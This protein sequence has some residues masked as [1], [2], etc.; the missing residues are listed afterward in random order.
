MLKNHTASGESLANISVPAGTM[1]AIPG[2][3]RETIEKLVL[4]ERQAADALEKAQIAMQAQGGEVLTRPAIDA[5]R[6]RAWHLRAYKAAG[7]EQRKVDE[8]LKRTRRAAIKEFAASRGWKHEGGFSVAELH[9]HSLYLTWCETCGSLC[10]FAV[11]RSQN[12]HNTGHHEAFC[13]RHRY[14]GRTEAVLQHTRHPF[15]RCEGFAMI[16]GLKVT[17]LPWSWYGPEFTAALFE[18]R[19]SK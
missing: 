12:G 16:A 9:N 1:P 14:N 15:E 19:V 17:R 10:R 2:S 11:E 8:Q 3:T 5:R 18:R 13:R 6:E 7:R 4:I